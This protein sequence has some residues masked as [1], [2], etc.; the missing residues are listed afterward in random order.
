MSLQQYT[1]DLEKNSH[2]IKQLQ[3]KILDQPKIHKQKKEINLA[4]NKKNN[5]KLENKTKEPQQLT[6][7]K[8]KSRIERERFIKSSKTRLKDFIEKDRTALKDSVRQEIR[9]ELALTSS[10][11][12]CSKSFIH[13]D[14]TLR[15]D[16]LIKYLHSFARFV[17]EKKAKLIEFTLMLEK[18]MR[19]YIKSNVIYVFIEYVKNFTLN[20]I[21]SEIEYYVC[22]NNLCYV[23]LSNC[24]KSIIRENL[25]HYFL[26]DFLG[27]AILKNNI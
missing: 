21:Y 1:Q 14:Q 6:K 27:I 18:P 9:E 15:I 23:C 10:K 20:K 24:K 7:D 17:I 3:N 5:N 4:K 8:S 2:E 11:R 19:R 16:H 13:K 22:A 12:D 25:S 26:V